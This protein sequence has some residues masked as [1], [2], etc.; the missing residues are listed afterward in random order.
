MPFKNLNLKK[1]PPPSEKAGQEKPQKQKPDLKLIAPSDAGNPNT[2]EANT[3]EASPDNSNSN[4]LP[5]IAHTFL[6]LISTLQEQKLSLSKLPGLNHYLATL[7][8]KKTG[9]V[10]K[11]A[12][13]DTEA[14]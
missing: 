14:D 9:K 7:K 12:M 13:L 5:K 2:D 1:P 6:Q 4:P 10:R 3:S 11:G 8:Q